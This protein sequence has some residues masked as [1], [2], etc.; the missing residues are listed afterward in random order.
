MKEQIDMNFT[1]LVACVTVIVVTA[2]FSVAYYN[3]NTAKLMSQNISEAVA[4]GIDPLSVRC[5]YANSTDNV[6]VAYAAS[7]KK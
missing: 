3:I 4:K 2:I 6:C 7:S 1:T 5:S